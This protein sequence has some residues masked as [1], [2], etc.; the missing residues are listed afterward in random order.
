MK[1]PKLPKL[2]YTVCN[3]I[4]LEYFSD[5]QILNRRLIT[6]LMKSRVISDWCSYEVF[7]L[8]IISASFPQ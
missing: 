8:L 6:G 3:E 1:L 5:V 2:P 7:W 4:L